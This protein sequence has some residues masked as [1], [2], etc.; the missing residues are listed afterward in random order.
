MVRSDTPETAFGLGCTA[1]RAARWHRTLDPRRA[2]SRFA[3][4]CPTVLSR[5]Q[6]GLVTAWQ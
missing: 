1:R 3:K 6:R 5:R 2:P 4:A